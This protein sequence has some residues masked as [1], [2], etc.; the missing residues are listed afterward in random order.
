MRFNTANP[1]TMESPSEASEIE[2]VIEME[3]ID[4][5]PEVIPDISDLPDYIRKDEFPVE[6]EPE[7]SQDDLNKMYQVRI[8]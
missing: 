2:L 4:S 8:P 3:I 6:D 5:E 1:N 7:F